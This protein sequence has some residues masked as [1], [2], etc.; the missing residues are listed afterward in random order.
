M[1]IA[2]ATATAASCGCLSL[3][4]FDNY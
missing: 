3:K 1:S 2:N 4:S